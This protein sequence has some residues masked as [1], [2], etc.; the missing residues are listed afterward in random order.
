MKIIGVHDVDDV[1]HWFDSPKRAELCGP[2]GIQVTAFR[3]P[4]GD[5]ST[6]AVLFESPDLETFESLLASP[7]GAEAMQHDGVRVDT[8]RILLA[9]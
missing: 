3:A 1:Q 7:A 5:S 4:A 9:E 8:I 6:V 2:L